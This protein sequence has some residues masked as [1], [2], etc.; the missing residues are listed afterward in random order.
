MII[1]KP[2]HDHFTIFYN[3]LTI[4]LRP[5]NAIVWQ[6]KLLYDKAIDLKRFLRSFVFANPVFCIRNVCSKIFG[7]KSQLPF[8]SNKISALKI[9]IFLF[10][11][12]SLFLFFSFSLFLFFSF[13]L[14]LF[15]SFSLGQ[16]V[17][18]YVCPFVCLYICRSVCLYICLFARMPVCISACLSVYLCVYECLYVCVFVCLSVCIFVFH[19]IQSRWVGT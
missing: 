5:S 14:F 17:C 3:Y 4:N 7:G 10:L 16:F 9:P 1:L 6:S 2:T 13:S 11:S 18:L 8:I 12:F 19:K 15:F